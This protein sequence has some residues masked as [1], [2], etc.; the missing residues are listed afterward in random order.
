MTNKEIKKLVEN[1][2]HTLVSMQNDRNRDSFN[3]KLN[4]DRVSM[5]EAKLELKSDLLNNRNNQ[6]KELSDKIQGLER[7]EKQ[8]NKIISELSESNG[9][10][11]FL[12]EKKNQEIEILKN[13]LK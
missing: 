7:I 9:N 6:V 12:L 11:E 5:L 13:K 8:N 3:L 1:L 10:L 4:K 2:E